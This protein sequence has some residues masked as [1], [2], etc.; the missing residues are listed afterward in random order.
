MRDA[1]LDE[2]TSWNRMGG[3]SISNLGYE[4]DSTLMAE[5]EEERNSLLM[6]VEEEN[7]KAS[8][9]LNIKLLRSW[10]LAPLLHGK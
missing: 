1:G 4:D 8:L 10:H 9:R 3:R 5:S 2:L 6:R 7:E